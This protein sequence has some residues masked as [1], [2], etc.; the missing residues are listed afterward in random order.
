MSGE[1][2]I[3]LSGGDS[4]WYAR[5]YRGIITEQ[6]GY[7]RRYFIPVDERGSQII[8][9]LMKDNNIKSVKKA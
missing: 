3:E 8:A 2:R 4:W 5:K 7:N 9:E 6:I 1:Y